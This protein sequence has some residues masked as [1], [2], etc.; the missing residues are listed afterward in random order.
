V[1]SGELTIGPERLGPA[2]AYGG[3]HPTPT[4][5]LFALGKALNGDADASRRG[6][7]PIAQQLGISLE[8]A[9]GRVLDLSCEKIVFAARNMVEGINSKPVYTVKELLSGYK[10][11]PCAIL[12]LGGPAPF[13]APRLEK[14]TG[15]QTCAVPQWHVA[16][17]IGAAMAKNTSEVTLFADTERGMALA[18]EEEFSR[19]V[20]K[21]FDR[22]DAIALAFE[23]LR[24]KCAE[25]GAPQPDLDLEVVEDNQFNMVRG[26]YTAGRNI[27]VKVQTRPGL[28]PDYRELAQSMFNHCLLPGAIEGL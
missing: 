8:Q 28:I 23:L 1:V 21:D 2:M 22:K 27:R 20:G 16:N 26:F 14:L 12:A 25:A 5:A 4:D 10:V 17:A 11:K 7:D 18:P 24:K 15:I 3:P 13:F 19:R 6:L 9:A